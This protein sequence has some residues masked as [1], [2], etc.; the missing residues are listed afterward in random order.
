[1]NR[2]RSYNCAAC[3]R[4]AINKRGPIN[5]AWRMHNER[6]YCKSCFDNLMSVQRE[7]EEQHDEE[8]TRESANTKVFV[9]DLKT[10]EK[11]HRFCLFD[12]NPVEDLISAP[13]EA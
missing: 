11:G 8:E 6:A 1:M 7:P 10:V 2:G 3:E 5:K 9:S 4:K 13:I 12:C